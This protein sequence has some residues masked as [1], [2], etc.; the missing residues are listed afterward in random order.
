MPTASN[1]LIRKAKQSIFSLHPRNTAL[2]AARI[3]NE[4]SIGSVLVMDGA[5]LQGIFTERDM[6]RRVVVERRDPSEVRLEEV[7]T[8]PVACAAPDTTLDELRMVVKNR[9]I[10][11]LPVVDGQSV[12][13]V[14]SIGDLNIAEAES[15]EQTIRYLSHYLN[16]P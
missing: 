5:N 4:Q 14:I 8:S 9:R 15:Q 3:M 12:I 13:G 6:L 11:H 7:M 1:L 2:D 16:V 10:R